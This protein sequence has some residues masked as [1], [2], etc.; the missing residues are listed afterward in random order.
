MNNRHS[1]FPPLT[2]TIFTPPP[3]S[4]TH[5]HIH[6]AAAAMTFSAVAL[7][8]VRRVKLTPAPAQS[9]AAS[10][11]A[12]VHREAVEGNTPTPIHDVRSTVPPFRK[13]M[14]RGDPVPIPGTGVTWSAEPAA[15]LE[16][17]FL[18]TAPWLGADCATSL[19][20]PSKPG[21]DRYLW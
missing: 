9:C 10:P 12:S 13:T 21:V 3:P 8:D 11:S 4:H 5:T 20:L 16:H 18:P 1:P 7:S 6:T 2:R 19:Q 14:L 17:L 15:D